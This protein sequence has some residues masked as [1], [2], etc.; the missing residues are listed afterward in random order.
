MLFSVR[1]SSIFNSSVHLNY[2]IRDGSTQLLLSGLERSS[3]AGVNISLIVQPT[4]ETFDLPREFREVNNIS[5]GSADGDQTFRYDVM[6][7]D[8]V[9]M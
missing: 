6:A 7:Y 9:T 8:F 1:T 5:I 2:Q 4:A 3:K